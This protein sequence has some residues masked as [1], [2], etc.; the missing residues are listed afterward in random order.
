M[1]INIRLVFQVDGTHKSEHF[2][3][4]NPS[5]K[6]VGLMVEKSHP[7]NRTIGEIPDS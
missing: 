6:F 5:R 2:V 7:Q 3:F 4:P 1:E